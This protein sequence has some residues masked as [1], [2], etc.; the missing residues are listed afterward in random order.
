MCVEAQLILTH[1]IQG[2]YAIIFIIIIG[3]FKAH[4]SPECL[5]N[6]ILRT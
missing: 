5:E 6:L 2:S 3:L 1:F 4:M